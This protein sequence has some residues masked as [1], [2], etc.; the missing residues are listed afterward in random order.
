MRRAHAK[1][2][3]ADSALAEVVNSAGAIRPKFLINWREVKWPRAFLLFAGQI[4]KGPQRVWLFNLPLCA[5][6]VAVVTANLQVRS[7]FSEGLLVAH[8]VK[9]GALFMAQTIVVFETKGTHRF[10][11]DSGNLHR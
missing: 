8:R 11:E 4:F 3:P 2:V 7:C 5:L 1:A 10:V 9:T 6:S